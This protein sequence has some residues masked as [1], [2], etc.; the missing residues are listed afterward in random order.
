MAAAPR[1]AK[2]L[3]A[4][5]RYVT[6]AQKKYKTLAEAMLELRRQEFVPAGEPTLEGLLAGILLVAAKAGATI[7]DGLIALHI[8]A[9]KAVIKA[10]S[11]Q[12]ADSVLKEVTAQM[13]ALVA[14]AES[15]IERAGVAL[16]EKIEAPSGIEEA[17]RS[18]VQQ[19]LAAPGS[20][21]EP[22]ATSGT[23]ALSPPPFT[24][25]AVVRT[26]AP[27]PER[28][29]QLKVADRECLMA[30]QLLIDNFPIPEGT[31]DG[32]AA[33][34]TI[35]IVAR[36]AITWTFD[37]PTGFKF[38]SARTLTN[39][40][41]IL[42]CAQPE[43]AQ[44]VRENAVA[45]ER[46]LGG[47][48]KLRLRPFKVVV[49]FVPIIFNPHNEAIWREVETDI[50]LPVNSIM[51]ARWIKPVARRYREQRFAHLLLTLNNP[52][53]ANTIIRSGLTLASKRVTVHKNL[54]EPMRCAKCHQY[55]AGHLARD[56]PLQRDICGTCG[57][58]HRTS[59]CKVQDPEDHRC[60][61]CDKRG[62]AT[63]SRDC[64]AFLDRLRRSDARHPENRLRFFPTSDP[65]S[66]VPQIDDPPRNSLWNQVRDGIA[67]G[68]PAT[69]QRQRAQQF[70]MTQATLNFTPH[71]RSHSPSPS[72]S[73]PHA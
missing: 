44:W 51:E 6:D 10:V 73:I 15:S 3:T 65:D 9:Q 52:V 34:E 22:G 21:E 50:D 33:G 42:E 59:E 55:D 48:A 60:T 61:V 67:A 24:Y 38:I 36:E 53:A 16:R 58:S 63:W 35:L 27:G 70:R 43:H 20:L 30:R 68:P 45:Y 57:S 13:A 54:A 12:V 39:G 37:V 5:D 72:R 2:P 56:C 69:S 23:S 18:G 28:A 7:A 17:V 49:E 29:T 8:Y 26:P 31:G 19:A 11:A 41:V 25:A 71:L 47:G 46:G 62:H 14:G 1:T 32:P 40:G 4:E 64:P 66:W